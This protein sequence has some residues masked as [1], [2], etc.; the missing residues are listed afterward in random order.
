M[1]LIGF[2]A[3]WIEFRCGA[4]ID[5]II[6]STHY[7]LNRNKK[8]KS[9]TDFLILCK[10]ERLISGRLVVYLQGTCTPVSSSE[11]GVSSSN[12]GEEIKVSDENDCCW[13]LQLAHA[14]YDRLRNIVCQPNAASFPFHNGKKKYNKTDKKCG[15]ADTC[16]NQ[17]TETDESPKVN[18]LCEM[19]RWKNWKILR[20]F[21]CAECLKIFLEAKRWR[22]SL[23]CISILAFVNSNPKLRSQHKK[24]LFLF[25]PKLQRIAS[26]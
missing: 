1:L 10:F 12:Q 16:D 18:K 21:L 22:W 6:C 2:Y 13:I 20:L 25:V 11:D 7:R 23:A 14:T 15:K 24:L 4:I 19:Q 5:P 8:I 26:G 17:Q 9:W 3:K